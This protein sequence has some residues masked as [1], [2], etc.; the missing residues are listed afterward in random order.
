M[1]HQKNCF[2]RIII[3]NYPIKIQILVGGKKDKKRS[4]PEFPPPTDKSLRT[5]S[6]NLR[7]NTSDKNWR[8][9]NIKFDG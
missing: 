2:N 5:N 4:D 1:S 3:K 7:E 6:V 8:E 9:I